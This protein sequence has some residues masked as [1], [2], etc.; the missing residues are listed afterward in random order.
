MIAARGESEQQALTEQILVS[1]KMINL[2]ASEG[3]AF[4]EKL[5]ALSASI[6]L[7]GPW[8]ACKARPPYAALTPSAAS[9]RGENDQSSASG[10]AI[11]ELPLPSITGAICRPG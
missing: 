4:L 9:C 6:F 2:N 5:D 1:D 3:A 7:V 8:W 10:A 11:P